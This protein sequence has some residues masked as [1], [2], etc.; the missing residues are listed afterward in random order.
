PSNEFQILSLHDA[1]PILKRESV[2]VDISSPN[3]AALPPANICIN[4]PIQ[5]QASGAETYQ[6]NNANLLNDATI[7]NPIATVS[8]TTTFIVRSEE[9][10]SE[11]QS[12]ENLVC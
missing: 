9:H 6:W 5:L 4:T 1:L 11:L 10:T 12:R 8:D 3:V 2:M 7:S